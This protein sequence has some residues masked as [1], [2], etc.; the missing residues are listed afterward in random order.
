MGAFEATSLSPQS[1]T[2][3]HKHSTA[4]TARPTESKPAP[5]MHCAPLSAVGGLDR[6]VAN[7]GEAGVAPTGV[8]I[9]IGI[10]AAVSDAL[11]TAIDARVGEGE[12]EWEGVWVVGSSVGDA[13][14][15]G[16]GGVGDALGVGSGGGVSAVP[17]AHTSERSPAVL[18]ISK[19]FFLQCQS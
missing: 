6:G 8:G 4:S 3:G 15:V 9:G 18:P 13:L 10:G 2:P 17:L 7:D 1:Q 5:G 14:G 16:N 12:D 11:N 19:H